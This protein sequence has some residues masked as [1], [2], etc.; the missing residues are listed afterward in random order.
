VP[1]K[2]PIG[3]SVTGEVAPAVTDQVCNGVVGIEAGHGARW[4]RL[5]RD[6]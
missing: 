6:R 1:E 4:R 3:A 5:R 2:G